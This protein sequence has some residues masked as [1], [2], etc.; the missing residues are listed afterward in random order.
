MSYL[1]EL[2]RELA[3]HGVRGGARRRILAEVDDHLRSDPDAQQ[4]FGAPADIANKFAAELGAHASRRA[5]VGAFAALAVAGAVY[6]ALVVS[7]SPQSIQSS[8]LSTAALILAPQV[9]FVAGVLALARALRTRNRALATAELTVLHRRT[10]IALAFGAVTMAALASSAASAPAYVAT[11]AAT[12]LLATAAVPLLASTRFRP[13][14]AGSAGDVF[15]DLGIQRLRRDPWR[16]ARWVALGVGA[17]VWL[18]GIVQGDPLDGLLRGAL[19]A[20]ACLA[21]F[22]VLGR[23]LGLRR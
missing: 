22:A 9:A 18:A 13:Q 4:R 5:A 12:T 23:Y 11:A 16:F 8:T 6:A 3:R 21:G 20:A 7:L 10:G 1:D 2:S 14:L 19:E 17:A 15:D